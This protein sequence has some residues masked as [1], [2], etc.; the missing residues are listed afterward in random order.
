MDPNWTQSHLTPSPIFN[1]DL[2]YSFDPSR[3]PVRVV[4]RVDRDAVFNDLFE[5]LDALGR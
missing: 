3:H 1:E 2:R 4:T 5:R